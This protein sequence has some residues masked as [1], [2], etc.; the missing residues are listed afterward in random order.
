MDMPYLVIRTSDG[1]VVNVTVGA[2]NASEGF[3][4][5]EQSGD[6]ASAGIGWTRGEDGTFTDTSA[7]YDPFAV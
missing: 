1:L 4:I 2:Q 7:D 3:E 5:V 6:S